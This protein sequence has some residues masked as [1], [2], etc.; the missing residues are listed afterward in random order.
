[1]KSSFD[2]ILFIHLQQG[3]KKRQV[4]GSRDL[5]VIVK[6]K[7]KM[8]VRRN[9]PS[10]VGVNAV[11]DA[12]GQRGFMDGQQIAISIGLGRLDP[13]NQTPS[14]ERFPLGCQ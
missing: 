10:S 14:K 11:G 6:P 5:D 2:Q 8:I 7:R 3:F 13:S 1:V 9:P 12:L 4:L